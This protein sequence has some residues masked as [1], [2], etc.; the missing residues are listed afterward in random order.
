VI[1]ERPL[2]VE[3]S[4]LG[5]TV[6]VATLLSWIK[7]SCPTVTDEIRGKVTATPEAVNITLFE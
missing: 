7:Y 2:I 5:C 3:P 4:V 6:P 1:L